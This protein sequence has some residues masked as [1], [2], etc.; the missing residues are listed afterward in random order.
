MG[1]LARNRLRTC[2]KT[3]EKLE[4]TIMDR[5]SENSVHT[6]RQTEKDKT[7]RP[8][9][10]WCP[11]KVIVSTLQVLPHFPK[12]IYSELS[13][14]IFFL[15][16]HCF[17]KHISKRVTNQICKKYLSHEHINVKKLK[18]FVPQL[19]KVYCVVQLNYIG[20]RLIIRK[21]R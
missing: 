13:Q 8:L 20:L 4:E 1:T 15:Y 9:R 19:I 12:M 10:H 3:N 21:S 17:F 18:R 11:K 2:P 7:I 5:Q 6:C 16:F 14:V